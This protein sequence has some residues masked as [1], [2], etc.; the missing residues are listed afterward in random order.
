MVVP[1]LWIPSMGYC[2]APSRSSRASPQVQGTRSWPLLPCRMGTAMSPHPTPSHCSLLLAS[3]GR[4]IRVKQRLQLW[5]H[6][7]FTLGG[8]SLPL[9]PPFLPTPASPN[10]LVAGASSRQSPGQEHLAIPYYADCASP[11]VSNFS[12]FNTPMANCKGQTAVC[13]QT[14]SEG[15]SNQGKYAFV[16]YKM[17][18]VCICMQY[19]HTVLSN[20]QAPACPQC[21]QPHTA[22]LGWFPPLLE[23]WSKPLSLRY[24][25][26][27]S[28]APART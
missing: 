13:P 10:P 1:R 12:E 11:P 27:F 8:A 21:P 4:G 3:T 14:L 15:T 19:V 23:N 2:L 16:V 20:S 18:Y 26:I 28:T 17:I 9:P 25:H 22:V 7:T 24:T 5:L 6:V